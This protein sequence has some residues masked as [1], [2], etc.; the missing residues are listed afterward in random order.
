MSAPSICFKSTIWSV[1]RR[2]KS[3]AFY[4]LITFKTFS[5]FFLLE[6]PT[7]GFWGLYLT[8]WRNAASTRG[9]PALRYISRTGFLAHR[10]LWE[11]LNVSHPPS[12]VSA[13]SFSWYRRSRT[14]ID[15][16]L[17]ASNIYL[18]RHQWRY[19]GYASTQLEYGNSRG[20]TE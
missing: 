20:G 1:G 5:Y 10:M 6:R 2:S 3:R 13:S 7:Q 12:S 9:G 16:S 19:G 8:L 15:V 18:L 4:L 17:R 11:W 14:T